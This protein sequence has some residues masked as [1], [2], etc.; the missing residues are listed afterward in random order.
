[1]G[2]FFYIS[3]MKKCLAFIC[4]RLLMISFSVAQPPA[5]PKPYQKIEPLTKTYK[6]EK[7]KFVM[8]RFQDNEVMVA[9][10]KHGYTLTKKEAAAA[11]IILPLPEVKNF[12]VESDIYYGIINPVFPKDIDTLTERILSDDGGIYFNKEAGQWYAEVM[13]PD[14]AVF[15][16]INTQTMDTIGICRKPVLQVPENET[17]YPDIS[18]GDMNNKVV[19]PELLH[20]QKNIKIPQGYKLI[21]ATV[22][23]AGFSNWV[24]MRSLNSTDLSVLSDL[25]DSCKDGSSIVTE[26]VTVMSPNGRL[27]HVTVP[28]IQVGKRTR[29]FGYDSSPKFQFGAISF[30]RAE[31]GRFKRQKKFY[32]SHGCEFVSAVVY[33]AGAGFPNVNQAVLQ[34]N[35]TISIQN[36]LQQCRPG[37]SVIFDNIRVQTKNDGIRTIDGV[38]FQLF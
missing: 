30:P 37:T 4:F 38:A 21:K 22:Y 27:M 2:A 7:I 19:T 17:I 26:N 29:A 10:R 6:G 34:E 33:F 28:A 11:G 36:L 20:Q 16:K 1:M 9:T 25:I 18:F 31:S 23:F 12:E 8:A 35:S 15:Y 14:T 32:I 24:H 5:L 13:I 3:K